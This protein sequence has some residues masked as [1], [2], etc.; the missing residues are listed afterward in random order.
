MG[1]PLGKGRPG[2]HIE[3]S[4][5]AMHY[6]GETLDIHG[7]GLDL[8]HPHHENEIAQ[9]EARTGKP[10]VRYWLHNN[11]LNINDEKMSKSLG[12]IFYNSDFIKKYTGEALKY[13]LLSGQYRSPIDF[14]EQHIR[15][16]LAALHRLYSAAKKCTSLMEFPSNKSVPL[17]DE[18]KAL[19]VL[20]DDFVTRFR[21]AMDDDF[22][23][24]KVIGYLFDYVR[25][26]N[27]Y[28]DRKEFRPSKTST[29]IATRFL[30]N[31]KLISDILNV[32]GE[33]CV[34][35][36]DALRT[37]I[38]NQR[39]LD[40]QA[41]VAQIE[42]RSLA[43]QCKDFATADTIRKNLLDQ[44]IQVMDTPKGTEWDIVFTEPVRLEVK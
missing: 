4:A 27:G 26:L 21:E 10:F 35:Y 36:L 9:S 42:A 38:L 8:V 30:E 15:E 29:D 44:G 6:L 3:C 16:S 7:G 33:D 25:R 37:T 14:S 11:L 18:E 12:N 17:T 43:R 40:P 24:A 41:I 23:T 1:E 2:W 5:M 19:Q 13:L 34:A 28:F 31:R 20:G 32:F 39:N 22:N